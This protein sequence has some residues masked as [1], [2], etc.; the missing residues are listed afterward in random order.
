M[1]DDLIAWAEAIEGACG[2][3]YEFCKYPEM[4]GELI[5]AIEAKDARIAELEAEDRENRKHWLDVADTS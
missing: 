1:S 4:I 2:D 5:E 3:E